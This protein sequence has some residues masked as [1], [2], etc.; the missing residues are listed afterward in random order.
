MKPLS[1]TLWEHLVLLP[2]GVRLQI[3][4]KISE[5]LLGGC[6][7]RAVEY[8]LSSLENQ[9]KIVWHRKRRGGR[10][11]PFYEVTVIATGSAEVL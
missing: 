11:R 8:A 3:S 4:E 5:E 2:P 9:G 7:L 10:R 1:E 6:T